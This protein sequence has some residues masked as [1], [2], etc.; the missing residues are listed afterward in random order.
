M[1]GYARGTHRYVC[2]GG[3]QQHGGA[4]CISFGATRV[5]QAVSA[6]LLNVIQPL[7]VDAALNAIAAQ[8]TE[9]RD[10]RRQIELALQQARYESERAR[11]QYDAVEPENRIVVAELERRW[12]QR[13]LT[14]RELEAKL[15]QID[16]QPRQSLSEAERSELLRL[17][18]NLERAWNHLAATA[19]TRKRILRTLLV[20]VVASVTDK[21]IHL[22]LHWQGGDHTQLKIIKPR[23]GQHRWALDAETTDIIRELARLMPDYQIASVLNRAGKRTGRDNTWTEARVR[24]FRNDHGIPVHRPGEQVERGE[25]NVLEAAK[26]LDTS[27]ATVRRLITNGQ[28][29]AR[30]ACPGAPWVIKQEALATVRLTSR[31]PASHNPGQKVMDF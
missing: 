18:T 5:D 1:V 31:C 23:N 11:R 10:R 17:G 13:L 16:Q 25:V 8:E 9:A 26:T 6:E 14:V 4:Y 2:H 22:I 19:E 27:R 24:S 15:E 12:N 28:L 7:G 21:E 20:E 29:E 30:Q 3:E